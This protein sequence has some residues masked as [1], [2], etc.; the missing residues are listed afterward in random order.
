M[1]HLFK[2]KPEVTLICPFCKGTVQANSCE[3]FGELGII[4][5]M[6]V[7]EEFQ[8]E[9]DPAEFLAMCRKKIEN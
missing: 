5:T 4:H 2:F 9:A 6:P 8:N 7:C 3:D 1:S